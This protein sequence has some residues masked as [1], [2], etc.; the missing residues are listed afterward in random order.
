MSWKVSYK[1]SFQRVF[2]KINPNIQTEILN[3]ADRIQSGEDGELLKYSWDSFYSWHF[4]RKP[5][6]RLLYIRYKCLISEGQYY[7]CKFDDINHSKEELTNCNGLIEF[8]LIGTREK[9][10]QL[11]KKN[12]QEIKVFLRK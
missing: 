7:K 5:E 4:N 9:F 11:Y 12:K 2:K 3:I 6:Y 10:N 8:V 1:S